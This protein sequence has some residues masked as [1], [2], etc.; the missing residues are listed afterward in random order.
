MLY[1][2]QNKKINFFLIFQNHIFYINIFFYG[3]RATKQIIKKND[4]Y[5]LRSGIIFRHS[6]CCKKS[7]PLSNADFLFFF[8]N[9]SSFL[10]NKELTIPFSRNLSLIRKNFYCDIYNDSKENK[11]LLLDLKYLGVINK[12]RQQK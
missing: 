7:F 8:R 4:S 6:M 2:F 12:N 3:N 9:E 11:K 10:M 1:A 5:F